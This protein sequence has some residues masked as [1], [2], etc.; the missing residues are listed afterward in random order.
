MNSEKFVEIVNG[1][2]AKFPYEKVMPK[3]PKVGDFLT[4]NYMN[5]RVYVVCYVGPVVEPP[6]SFGN[7]PRLPI[8]LRRIA[9]VDKDR[10]LVL[11]HSK[12]FLTWYYSHS[13]YTRA[14]KRFLEKYGL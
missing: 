11:E 10:K 2:L 7:Y 3:P 8:E 5:T 13:Y 9:S 14:S 6:Y 1:V 12:P 4:R